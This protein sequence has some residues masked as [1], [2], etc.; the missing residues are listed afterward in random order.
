MYFHR[1]AKTHLKSITNTV[2]HDIGR[3]LV[4]PM[5]SHL[6]TDRSVDCITNPIIDV[7]ARMLF[8]AR[9]CMSCSLRFLTW[10][11]EFTATKA[12]LRM[13][14]F[15]RPRLDERKRVCGVRA[16]ARARVRTGDS[17]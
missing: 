9:F 2:T 11:F 17:C 4:Y 1:A 8:F 15:H 6:V 7:L 13:N 10:S 14:S 16:R 5:G 12:L 3:I